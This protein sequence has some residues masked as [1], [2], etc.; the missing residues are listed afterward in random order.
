[1]FAACSRSEVGIVQGNTGHRETGETKPT[2]DW[3]LEKETAPSLLYH[4]LLCIILKKCVL[5][6]GLT[7]QI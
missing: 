2:E 6:T 1:M 5:T 4:L 3:G 7:T